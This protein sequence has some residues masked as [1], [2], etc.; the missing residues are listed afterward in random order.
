MR[1]K[2]RRV[3]SVEA[4]YSLAAEV[5]AALQG[6]EA[7][8]LYGELGSGKTTFVQGLARALGV[9][10]PVTSQTFTIAAEYD[11]PPALPGEA[12]G[13]VRVLV[14]VDLYRLTSETAVRD[15]AVREVLERAGHQECVTVIEWADRLGDSLG[16]PAR[17]LTFSHGE[18]DYERVVT[19]YGS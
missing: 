9:I 8:L 19:G 16:V 18:T 6:G 2:V 4:M 5:A 10:E 17:R 3:S 13:R 12:A 14:H 11:V 7:L 1:R 15:P